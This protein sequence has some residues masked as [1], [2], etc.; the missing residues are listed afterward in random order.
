MHDELF[1]ELM[2][3]HGNFNYLAFVRQIAKHSQINAYR[4]LSVL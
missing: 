3:C 4:H 1:K 2:L